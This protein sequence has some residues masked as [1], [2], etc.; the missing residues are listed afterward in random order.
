MRKKG[1]RRTGKNVC[2]K[3][4]DRVGMIAQFCG[5]GGGIITAAAAS[6]LWLKADG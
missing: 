4:L 5:A 6:L 2:A 3:A 1:G